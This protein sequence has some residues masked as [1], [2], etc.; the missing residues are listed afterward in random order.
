MLRDL[1]N[2][3]K[4]FPQPDVKHKVALDSFKMI[5][6]TSVTTMENNEL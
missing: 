5:C 4:Y 6:I 3:G 2:I 1:Q